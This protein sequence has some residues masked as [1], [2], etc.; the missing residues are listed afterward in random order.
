MLTFLLIRQFHD[1]LSFVEQMRKQRNESLPAY[2]KHAISFGVLAVIAVLIGVATIV[3]GALDVSNR[4]VMLAGGPLATGILVREKEEI[5]DRCL[6]F[7][8]FAC[9]RIFSWILYI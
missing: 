9:D 1:N 6:K 7:C 2:K 4:G 5:F 3:L 8:I